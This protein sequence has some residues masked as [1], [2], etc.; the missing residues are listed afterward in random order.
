VPACST[1]SVQV[2]KRQ[3]RGGRRSREPG[4]DVH[5]ASGGADEALEVIGAASDGDA[6]AR[7]SWMMA[8]SMTP[9]LVRQRMASAVSRKVDRGVL[10]LVADDANLGVQVHVQEAVGEVGDVG[11]KRKLC[12]SVRRCG[13]SNFERASTAPRQP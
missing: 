5:G 3:A 6:L 9:A 1:A 7:A 8:Y 2:S 4:L 12:V 11:P 13:A 10:G